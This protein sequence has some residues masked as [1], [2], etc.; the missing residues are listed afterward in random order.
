MSHQMEARASDVEGALYQA[1]LIGLEGVEEVDNKEV[2]KV[3]VVLQLN[4][5]IGTHFMQI[6]LV[7]S[8][9]NS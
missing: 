2:W 3:C 5:G 1:G 4:L 6:L 8:Q 9:K 7:V